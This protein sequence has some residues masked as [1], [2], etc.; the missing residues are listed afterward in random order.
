MKAENVH[1]T[2]LDKGAPFGAFS[3]LLL[4]LKSHDIAKDTPYSDFFILSKG[5]YPYF[6]LFVL[7]FLLLYRFFRFFLFLYCF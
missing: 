4:V 3:K 2:N 6:I 7:V 1:C 5:G